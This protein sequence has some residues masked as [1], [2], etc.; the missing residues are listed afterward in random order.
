MFKGG[1]VGAGGSDFTHTLWN[2]MQHVESC[3]SFKYLSVH[4]P[5]RLWFCRLRAN[6]NIFLSGEAQKKKHRVC[7]VVYKSVTFD[8]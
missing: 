3:L 1:G 8:H 4:R 6:A 2:V 5:G 7:F